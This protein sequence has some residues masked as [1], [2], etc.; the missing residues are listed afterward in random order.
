LASSF[1]LTGSWAGHYIQREQEHPINVELIQKEQTLSGSMRDGQSEFDYSVSELA[2]EAGLPPGADEQIEANI[3]AHVSSSPASPIRYIQQL[4]QE[5]VIVGV[6]AGSRVDFVKTYKGTSSSGF[7]VGDQFLGFQKS[8][9][10][11]HYRGELSRDGRTIEGWWSID[12]DPSLGS[13][14]AEGTFVLRRK[15][16]A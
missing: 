4:P 9:H 5:S 7:K 12:P 16:N 15:E 1:D 10:A 6:C 11:V 13:R 14:R 2:F 3:R 8:G